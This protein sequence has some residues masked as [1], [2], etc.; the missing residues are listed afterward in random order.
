MKRIGAKLVKEHGDKFN[1]S[2]DHNKPVAAE[3]L[4]GAYSKKLRNLIAGYVTQ[5][6]KQKAE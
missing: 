4:E 3:L 1:D 2:F 6:V 5:L